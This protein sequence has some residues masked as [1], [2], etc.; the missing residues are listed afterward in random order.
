MSCNRSLEKKR[1]SRTNT[2]AS[3]FR[4]H[5]TPET[6]LPTGKDEEERVRMFAAEHA[7]LKQLK[8]TGAWKKPKLPKAS[9]MVSGTDGYYSQKGLWM[10]SM[11]AS[12]RGARVRRFWCSTP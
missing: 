6:R 4:P 9:N 1:T 12:G 5:P 3:S 8:E 7:A 2:N 11:M 10:P